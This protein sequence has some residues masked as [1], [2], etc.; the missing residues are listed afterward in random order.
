MAAVFYA[1]EFDGSGSSVDDWDNA[2][3]TL[4]S[5]LEK[6]AA[7]GRAPHETVDLFDRVWR[8]EQ[9]HDY[10]NAAKLWL[11][12]QIVLSTAEKNLKALE[13][14]G[15]DPEGKQL[16]ALL[17]P[18]PKQPATQPSDDQLAAAMAQFVNRRLAFA[19]KQ[20]KG[21]ILKRL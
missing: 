2:H 16:A 8:L 5:W 15:R 13:L 14:A 21:G 17:R 11:R 6:Q 19:S 1:G 20:T 18:N 10:E 7:K 3:R 9:T 4:A 12:M